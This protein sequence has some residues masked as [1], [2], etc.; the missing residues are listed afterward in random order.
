MSK[1]KEK[2]F[3]GLELSNQLM[4]CAKKNAASEEMS[5]SAYVRSLL[6]KDNEK[7]AR[8]VAK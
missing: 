1:Q 5:I 7:R 8:R 3:I 6:I 4:V 2:S